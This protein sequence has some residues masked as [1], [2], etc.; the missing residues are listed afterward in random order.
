MRTV[1]LSALISASVRCVFCGDADSLFDVSLSSARPVDMS[2]LYQAAVHEA[3]QRY[4]AD[5]VSGV[6]TFT[7]TC[8]SSDD[9][10]WSCEHWQLWPDSIELAFAV[11]PFTLRSPPTS[12]DFKHDR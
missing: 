9:V 11:Q 10:H 12:E 8:D 2:A 3:A 1:F 7:S 6:V 4:H 5:G